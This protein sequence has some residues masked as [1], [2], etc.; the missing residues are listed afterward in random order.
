MV[1]IKVRSR[2]NTQKTWVRLTHRAPVELAE[3]KKLRRAL[4]RLLFEG[5][6]PSKELAMTTLAILIEL[7]NQKTVDEALQ[8]L[9]EAVDE[10]RLAAALRECEFQVE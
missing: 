6:E 10:Q 1:R 5:V 8:R 3:G 4:A 2:K 9:I 7:A